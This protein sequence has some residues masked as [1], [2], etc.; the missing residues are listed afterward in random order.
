MLSSMIATN[1]ATVFAQFSEGIDYRLY[2]V[3]PLSREELE[4]HWTNPENWSAVYYCAED[5]RVI[6]PKRQPSMGWTINFA[7]PLAIPVLLLAIL[8]PALPIVLLIRYHVP[9][10]WFIAAMAAC[11]AL[12][13]IACHWEEATRP[14]E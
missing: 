8:V 6:V 12:L 1:G 14:R 10:R 9:F 2:K 4:R 3:P 7:H 13:A 5:P 11:I